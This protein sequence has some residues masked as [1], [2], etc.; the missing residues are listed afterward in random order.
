MSGL[1][2]ALM[3]LECHVIPSVAPFIDVEICLA[4]IL[5]NGTLKFAHSS[6]E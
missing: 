3:T 6:E 4:F 5:L 2:V 1:P